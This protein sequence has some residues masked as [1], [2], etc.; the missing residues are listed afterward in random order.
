MS[1]GDGRMYTCKLSIVTSGCS[2]MWLPRLDGVPQTLSPLQK[3]DNSGDFCQNLMGMDILHSPTRRGWKCFGPVW[4][5]PQKSAPCSLGWFVK[6]WIGPFGALSKKKELPC[7][8]WGPLARLQ[9][10]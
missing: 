10:P 7:L 3:I 2:G 1:S 5:G 6:L 8:S 4:F 9:P